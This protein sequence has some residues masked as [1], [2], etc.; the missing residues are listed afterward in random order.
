[1]IVTPFGDLEYGSDHGINQWIAAHDIR[2]RTYRKELS[3]RGSTIQT[4]PLAG[5][6]EGA[7]IIV[8]YLQHMA[9]IRT[10]QN[11]NSVAAQVISMDPWYDEEAFYR[12]HQ[13]HNLLHTRLDQAL[14]VVNG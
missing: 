6:V 10:M 3:R 5:S 8:H 1:M 4:A 13:V 9:F 2:H 11:D 12:W 7:W 14:G